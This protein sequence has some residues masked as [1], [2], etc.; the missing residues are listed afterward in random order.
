VGA[1]VVYGAVSPNESKLH[2]S[3]PYAAYVRQPHTS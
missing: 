1:V 3:P 2:A